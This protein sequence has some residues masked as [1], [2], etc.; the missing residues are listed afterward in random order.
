MNYID[1]IAKTVEEAI[2]QGY[3]QLEEQGLTFERSE[4]LEA[5]SNGFL[6]FGKKDAK[7]RVFY[8][9]NET[10]QV[11][12]AVA[13]RRESKEEVAP[14]SRKETVKE[15][16]SEPKKVKEDK[17]PAKVAPAVDDDSVD[18]MDEAPEKGASEVSPEQQ[19][20]IA[21]KGKVFLQGMFEKMGISVIIEKMITAERITFQVHG[22]DLGILIGK[23]GQTLDAIQYLTNLVANKDEQGRYHIMVDVEG[24]RVRREKT[25]QQLAKRMADKARRNRRKVSLEPMNAYERKVIHMALQEIQHIV[26]TSE[27]EGASRHIV[28]EYVR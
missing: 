5:P 25:L 1:V 9:G 27:G 26:T 12:N 8:K 4:V 23:H 24:Y 13:D 18:D 11:V 17:F 16:A 15:K 7:V 19:A 3:A 10:A 14:V 20:Q 22:D 21:E 28:I 2:D 6:G